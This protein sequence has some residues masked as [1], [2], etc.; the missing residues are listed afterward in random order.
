[1]KIKLLSI[2][3]VFGL[4]VVAAGCGSG[5]SDKKANE[6]YANGVCSAIGD[7]VTE[8]KSL[9]TVSPPISSATLQKKLT[10]FK[11][12]TENLV[13]D[14]KAV[15]PPN[16]TEGQN[17][18]KQVSLFVGQVQQTAKAVKSAAAQIPSNASLSQI[19]PILTPL[20]PQLTSLANAAQ[21][22][23][24]SLKNV[25]GSLQSAFDSADACKNLGG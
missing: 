23:A 10:Q 19:V 18:Q 13:S 8:V 14:V 5:N 6:A 25:G 22:T 11:T 17:A 20:K 24:K 15:P 4:A 12:A 2:V 21:S 16:T 1:M 9:A 7:W 3:V